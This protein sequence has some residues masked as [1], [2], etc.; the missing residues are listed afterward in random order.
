MLTYYVF[1]RF[2]ASPKDPLVA[3][4]PYTMTVYLTDFYLTS[5]ARGPMPLFSRI[6]S[7][8]VG[9]VPAEASAATLDYL[10]HRDGAH[11]NSKPTGS[12]R[13][14]RSGPPSP[15]TASSNCTSTGKEAGVGLALR[16]ISDADS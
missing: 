4:S 9:A 10:W 12:G 16:P 1:S 2:R 14:T 6:V 11:S 15:V 7:C 8:E 3:I 5:G 13:G